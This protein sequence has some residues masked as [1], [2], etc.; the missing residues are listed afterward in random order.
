MAATSRVT[1]L[2]L[3]LGLATSAIAIGLTQANA[4]QQIVGGDR[5]SIAD[6]SYVVYLTTKDGFQFCGGTLVDDNKVITAAHCT[7]GKQPADIFVVA[8]REDKESG[9]GATSPVREI[10]VHPAFTDVRS[11]SDVSVLTLEQRLPYATLDLP[12]TADTDL[13]TVGQ[14]GLILGW[15]RTAADGQPSRYLLKASVP[16]MA[17]PDCAKSYPAYK[18]EAMVCAGVP[19]GGVDSCQGDSGGPLVVDGRLVGI[20][21]WGEG[22]AAPG[23]PGVYTRVLAYLDLLEA[24]V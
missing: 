5:A 20:T 8:G 9:A 14:P 4:D 1:R 22:C 16:L 17:D 7:A 13:Y 21:S 19:Q 23:K 12:G 18:A 11:G 2:L 10:W 3:A 24:Q 6:H 15:G